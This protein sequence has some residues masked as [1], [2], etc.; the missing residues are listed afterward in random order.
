MST[1]LRI[2]NSSSNRVGY[3]ST[4]V[5]RFT[6]VPSQMTRGYSLCDTF[7]DIGLI[8]VHSDTMRSVIVFVLDCK[9]VKNLTN[10]DFTNYVG[11]LLISKDE[12]INILMVDQRLTKIKEELLSDFRQARKFL[13]NK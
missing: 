10:S 6:P 9:S 2:F 12:R 11:D 8:V 1:D 3:S 13:A 7:K 4:I 5:V